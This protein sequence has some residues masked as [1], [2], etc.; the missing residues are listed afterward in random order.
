[1]NKKYILIH[2]YIYTLFWAGIG[3]CILD[4]CINCILFE[5][6]IHVYIFVHLYIMLYL[7]CVWRCD[8]LSSFRHWMFLLM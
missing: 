6:E 1:M 7:L 5:Q 2:L 4:S 8:I 3:D